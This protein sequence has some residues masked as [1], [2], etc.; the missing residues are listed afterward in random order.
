MTQEQETEQVKGSFTNRV[1]QLPTL[2]F[3]LKPERNIPINGKY[4]SGK[5]TLTL[6]RC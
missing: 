1:W 2:P 4:V 3:Y 5:T 6:P